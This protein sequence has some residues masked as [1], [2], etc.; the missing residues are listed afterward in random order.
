MAFRQAFWLGSRILKQWS[1]RLEG[2]TLV[3]QLEFRCMIWYLNLLIESVL[4]QLSFWGKYC[5]TKLGF[6]A[7]S[8]N[9]DVRK[10][11]QV[12]YKGAPE[13]NF[14]FFDK[15]KKAAILDAYENELYGSKFCICPRGNNHVGSVC[16]TESMTFGCVPGKNASHK[17][18]LFSF[19]CIHSLCNHTGML[20]NFFIH[21]NIL[22]FII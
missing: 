2:L 19:C 11:L 13:F 8:L 5:R 18:F 22:T 16:L 1:Y 12:F 15:M 14:H 20:H 21:K 17:A 7:G 9:S 6:W 4:F 3:I 10:N